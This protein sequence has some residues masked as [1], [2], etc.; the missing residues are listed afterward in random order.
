MVLF[1]YD[2]NHKLWLFMP[3]PCLMTWTFSWVKTYLFQDMY[4]FIVGI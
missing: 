4:I 2:S 1:T 3:L